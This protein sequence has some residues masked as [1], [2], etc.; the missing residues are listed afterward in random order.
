MS[1]SKKTYI[2]HCGFCGDGLLRLMCCDHCN[3]IMAVCDECEL[4]WSQIAEVWEDPRCAASGT[5]PA[6]PECGTSNATWTPLTD[7][8][9]VDNELAEFVVGRSA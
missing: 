4:M 6:C 3:S 5:F 2:A 1:K 8:E 9:I 7:D